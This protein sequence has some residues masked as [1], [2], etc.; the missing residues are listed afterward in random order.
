MIISWENPQAGFDVFE[1]DRG[2]NT[3]AFTNEALDISIVATSADVL[4]T[5]VDQKGIKYP[6]DMLAYMRRGAEAERVTQTEMTPK[7][8]ETMPETIKGA[9]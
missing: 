1:F 5:E 2:T 3:F 7:E 6:S 9:G 4:L 8:W